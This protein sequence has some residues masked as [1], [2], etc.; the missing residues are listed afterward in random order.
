MNAGEKWGATARLACAS[1]RSD[2]WVGGR[3]ARAWHAIALLAGLALGAQ[4][5]A[6]DT[7][8]YRL[9]V[10]TENSRPKVLIVF[11]D[12]GSMDTEVEGEPEPYDPGTTYPN[13]GNIRTGRLY[14][15]TGS[16][17]TPPSDRTSNWFNAEKNRCG[18]SFNP[19]NER[20]FYTGN[21]ARWYER[22]SRRRTTREWRDLSSDDN[23]PIHVE[24]RQDVS[25]RVDENG[26]GGGSP[27]DGYPQGANPPYKAQRVDN[28]GNG[29][30]S[31]RIYSANYMNWYYGSQASA[32]RTRLEIAQDV[33]STIVEANT[34]IDFGLAVFNRNY[35]GNYKGS[36]AYDGARVVQRIIENMT[37]TNRANLVNVVNSLDAEGS[38]PICESVYEAYRYLSGGAVKYGLERSNSDVPGRDTEAESGEHYLSPIGDCQYAYII[39]MTDGEPQYDTD[40]N[41]SIES[42]TGKTCRN[43][44]N[45]NG[46]LEKNCLPEIAE[47]MYNTDLDGDASN[48]EQKGILYTIGF[49]TDQQLLEDAASKGGGLYYTADNAAQL[50]AAFQGALTAIL[51]TRS[52]FTSPA[53]AANNTT[54]TETRN[55]VYF[56]LFEPSNGT[57][58]A[59]N[60][61]KLSVDP[62]TGELRDRNGSAALSASSGV[63]LDAAATYWG[64]GPSDGAKV[65][66]GGAGG[67]LAARDPDARVLKTNTGSNGALENFTTENL[68][69]SAYGLD[70]D[71][72][73]HELFQVD[74][75]AEFADLVAWTRG[76]SNSAK[77]A[78]RDWILGDI[79]HSTPVILDYGAL[80][81]HSL[82]SPDLRIVAGTNAGFLHMFRDSDGAESWAFF[83]KELA[84]M[85]H[86]RKNDLAGGAK[87]YGVDGEVAVYRHDADRDGT[88]DAADGDKMYI[89]FGLRRGG[90]RYYALDVTNP[91]SPSFMWERSEANTGFEE[92]GQSW[93]T[94]VVT[95]IPGHVD[96][97]GNL[98]PVVVFGGG[99]DPAYD[100]RLTTAAEVTNPR[101][102]GV[103]VVDAQ[104]GALIW[105]A[106]PASG[107]ATNLQVS[108]M[109]HSIAAQVSARDS[110]GDG[111]TDRIYAADV[112][113]NVWRLDL[114]GADKTNWRATK[115]AQLA[116]DGHAGDRRFFYKVDS[117]PTRDGNQVYDAVL[118]GSGDR[119]NPNATDN[120]DRFYMLKD[121]GQATYS[122]AVD[123]DARPN[124]ARCDWPL[125]N[126]D[127]FDATD[128]LIQQGTD[129]QK[130][131]ANEQMLASSG[132]YI[133]LSGGEKVM[134]R[135]Y[136]LAGRVVFTTFA[137][138]TGADAVN[139]CEPTPGVARLYAVRL[140]DA[141]AVID[142]NRNDVL[143]KIDRSSPIGSTI[144]DVPAIHVSDD[145]TVGLI[146]PPG[147]G[148]MPPADL[149]PF[150]RFPPVPV[151]T[152]WYD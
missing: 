116:G 68:T 152:Y 93:S 35:D 58:W 47:Y 128:N 141:S 137:P 77:T 95:T 123:C 85:L 112:G 63:L 94:P 22:T 50:T 57:N 111:L 78:R 24:C 101:G 40:A 32:T 103:F 73:L 54:R 132:W 56:A 2:A 36:S 38:T 43:Y 18:S 138:D 110:N 7:E 31:Y 3:A 66:A 59:G 53:V 122:T 139:R 19:L 145:G 51:N 120:H 9:E 44:R 8:I 79:L 21:F 28:V 134:S 127:L 81:G 6:D 113:G 14:W 27:G 117:V 143:T 71:D 102:R 104:T 144:T 98:K 30:R 82:A 91:D 37:A 15:A 129:T 106:T 55:E 72:A 96:N 87:V 119:S 140:Q 41:N 23:Q 29:W 34:G 17:G 142:F 26:N 115:F 76:W 33:I 84:P 151:Q 69:R 118:V 86:D 65:D 108:G 107:S 67:L 133:D 80:N 83:P 75:A 74:D 135:S 109:T 39:L 121:F 105:S 1:W 42:L 52:A 88:I 126:A 13:V 25:E 16:S 147:S 64:A 100:D 11:D 131:E 125:T 45:A 62:E 148:G 70:S 150:A 146:L 136:T 48:G 90:S 20:G 97:A 61:K 130:S 49:A 60:L 124:D 92:L 99:Y 46:S 10:D 89:F 5:L 12:S 114:P 4:A 149:R